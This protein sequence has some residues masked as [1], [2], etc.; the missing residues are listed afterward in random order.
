MTVEEDNM[1][2]LLLGFSQSAVADILGVSRRTLYNKIV[3]FP[4]P[5]DHGHV[6]IDIYHSSSA[7]F[8]DDEVTDVTS[9]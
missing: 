7:H 8:S 4:N 9:D 3:A 6:L 2:C 1:K 5:A